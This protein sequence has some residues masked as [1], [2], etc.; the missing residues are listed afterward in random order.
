M[1]GAVV[2]EV[3][4]QHDGLRP[5]TFSKVL[6]EKERGGKVHYFLYH[7]ILKIAVAWNIGRKRVAKLA[8]VRKMIGGKGVC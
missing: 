6:E 2:V 8:G 3:D 1:A 7:G 5:I 4:V